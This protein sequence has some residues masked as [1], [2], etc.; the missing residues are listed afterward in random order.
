MIHNSTYN[1]TVFYENSNG[2]LIETLSGYSFKTNKVNYKYLTTFLIEDDEFYEIIV[3]YLDE[4]ECSSIGGAMVKIVAIKDG[5]EKVSNTFLKG[6]GTVK[7]KKEII[8]E[9]IKS[10]SLEY[11]YQLD[12]K[13]RIS[14]VLEN[15]K[16][17]FV[18]KRTS[19]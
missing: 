1:Y 5:E 7:L 4:D 16:Y 3:K 18:D 11:S 15:V 14:E 17:I 6:S 19:K 9:E 8:G 10:I 12:Y 13:N 2:D